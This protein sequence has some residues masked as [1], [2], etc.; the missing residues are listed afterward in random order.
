MIRK[1]FI[2]VICL[3]CITICEAGS[4]GQSFGQNCD[5]KTAIV[6]GVTQGITEF[7]PISSTGHM[8]LISEIFNK[9]INR[10]A[11]PEYDRALNSYFAIIQ[12]GSILA[13]ILMFRGRILSMILALC[14]RSSEGLRL[15]K[16]LLISFFPAA[17]AGLFLDGILQKLLYNPTC[18]ACA[19]IFGAGLIFVA[20]KRYSYAQ[21]SLDINKLQTLS[22]LKIGLWQCLALIPGMSRSMVTILGGYYCKLK[23]KDAAE[24][25]FLLGL[26][27]LSSATMFKLIKDH[28]VIFHYFSAP[29]FFIGILVAFIFSVLSIR[30]FLNYLSSKGMRIF[31]WYRIL[32][33][34]LIL[35]SLK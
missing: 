19:L 18:I 20:E 12:F 11:S 33:G 16:S 7:L 34:L 14:G 4:S 10:G 35:F 29:M 15:A 2:F 3:N 25:S 24:Y 8:I 5:C 26:I 32:L 9:K 31:A 27:L 30:I 6:L 23:R 21:N 17:F 22:Y 1:I 13:V 28:E